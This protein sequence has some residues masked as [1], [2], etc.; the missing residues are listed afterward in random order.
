LN[1]AETWR[2]RQVDQKYLESFEMWR[3]RRME[4]ISW[5]DRVRHEQVLQ[6][7]LPAYNEKKKSELDLSHL[8][9][10]LS[11]ATRY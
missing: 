9:W 8:A 4:K 5:A 1:E 11:S 3:W 6:V 7:L 2:L 10:E